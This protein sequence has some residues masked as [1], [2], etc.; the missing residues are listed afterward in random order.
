M[1]L[2]KLF[3]EHESKQKTNTQFKKQ[4]VQFFSEN[5]SLKIQQSLLENLTSST[6]KNTLHCQKNGSDSN[7]QSFSPIY[8]LLVFNLF[9]KPTLI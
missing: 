5:I 8:L 6:P 7:F 4:T 9:T 3:F 2:E 1:K